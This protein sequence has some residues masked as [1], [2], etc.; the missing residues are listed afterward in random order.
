LLFW[1]AF[2]AQYHIPIRVG[3]RREYAI[4]VLY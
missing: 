4:C 3:S 2:P 1:V